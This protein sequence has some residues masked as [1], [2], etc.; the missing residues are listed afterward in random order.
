M[1]SLEREKRLSSSSQL[2]FGELKLKLELVKDKSKPIVFD[3][4]MKPAGACSWRGSYR[5]LGLKYSE[6]G[7]GNANWNG[8]EVGWQNDGEYKEYEKESFKL[9]EKPTTQQFLDMLYALSDKEMVGYKGGGFT[10]HKNVSVYFGNYG[11]S[12]VYNYK[13]K[14]YATV[15]PVNV[16]EDEEKVTIITEENE[17]YL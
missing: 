15:V 10:M 7:G 16:V 2:L 8:E 11:E 4:G 13:G 12:S 5:E 17:Y 9:P 6:N 14:E 3:F 1:M